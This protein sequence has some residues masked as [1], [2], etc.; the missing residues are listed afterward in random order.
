MTKTQICPHCRSV[1]EINGRLDFKAKSLQVINCPVC[2]QDIWLASGMW[3]QAWTVGKVIK[4]EYN[5]A[6]PVLSS[7]PPGDNKPVWSDFKILPDLSAPLKNLSDTARQA[8]IAIII[9]LALVL[10]IKVSP[11]NVKSAK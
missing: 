11:W 9:I 1:F 6:P 3:P 2:G 7:P 4:R 8:V 10:L 5:P